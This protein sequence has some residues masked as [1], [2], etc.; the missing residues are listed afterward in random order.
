[1]EMKM[2]DGLRGIGLLATTIIAVSANAADVLVENAFLPGAGDA[3]GEQV[4]ILIS[5]GRIQSIGAEV[6][7]N[8]VERFDAGG[9]IVTPGYIDSGTSVGLAEVSGLGTSRDGRVE[10]VRN[11]AGFNVWTALNEGSSLIPFAP[12]DGVTRGVI[13]PSADEANF[14]GESA[15]VRFVKGDKFLA[16]ASLAQHLYLREWNRRGAGGSRGNALQ[17]VLEDLDEAA[18]FLRDQRQYNSNKARPFSLS[19]RE[20]RALGRVIKG[21]RLLVVHV[22]RAADIRKVVTSFE[23]FEDVKLIIAGG[24]E[25]WRL[26]PMLAERS[27]P[28]L[29]NVLDNVPES[30]DRLGAR[31]DSATILDKAGVPI[32]FMSTTP[33][34]EFRS[35][36]QAA[37]VA[38]ANGLP[39][40]RAL[41][42]LTEGP[43]EIWGIEGGRLAEGEVAD[44]VFWDGD[45]IEIMSAPQA[46]M[47]DGRWVDLTTRQQQLSERYR[48]LLKLK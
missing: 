24:V 46:V 48:D 16:Q 36:T 6:T 5:E 4:T 27:I 13:T 10:E 31:L 11:A 12:T 19:T 8:D 15:L 29:L 23:R 38:V 17:L 47:I 32:A 25:A 45:P 43:A 22:D 34:S 39:W 41:R 28:V 2:M 18:R 44:L 37:G 20:L 33:Y 35:L 21:E 30:F 3:K 14:A 7:A 42:A 40:D 9:A 1:M 26:A